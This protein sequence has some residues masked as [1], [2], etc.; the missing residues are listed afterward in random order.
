MEGVI[1]VLRLKP[2][3][4]VSSQQPETTVIEDKLKLKGMHCQETS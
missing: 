2:S 4:H 1:Q 3:V